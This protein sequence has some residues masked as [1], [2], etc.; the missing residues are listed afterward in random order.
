MVKLGQ[1]FE[2]VNRAENLFENKTGIV[3]YRFIVDIDKQQDIIK[4]LFFAVFEQCFGSS[5]Y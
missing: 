3:E 1:E 5:Y 4:S 2:F